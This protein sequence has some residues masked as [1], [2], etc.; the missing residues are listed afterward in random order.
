MKRVIAFGLLLLALAGLLLGHR[1][2]AKRFTPGRVEVL[3]GENA[4]AVRQVCAAVPE[5]AEDEPSWEEERLVFNNPDL[6]TAQRAGTALAQ[7]NL[8]DGVLVLDYS[9]ATQVLAQSGRLWRVAAAFAALWLLFLAA[10]W[11]VTL[12][13]RRSREALEHQYLG[14]YL[15]DSAVRLMEKAIAFVA[16]AFGAALLVRYLVKCSVVLPSTLL[17][18]GSL[19]QLSHYRQWQEYTFPEGVLSAYG[20]TLQ[21]Q[22]LC[23]HCLAALEWVVLILLAVVIGKNREAE[24]K[25]RCVSYT[26]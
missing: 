24:E 16:G 18:Q 14:A 5:L 1:S 12:E 23:S 21:S 22:L 6:F 25:E 19:F 9:W 15:S 17:P 2:L 11:Q 3:C 26:Q 13:L 20:R 8:A 7:A 10:R 4:E